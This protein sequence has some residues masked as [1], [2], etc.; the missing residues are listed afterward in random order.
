MLNRG[1]ERLH[2]ENSMSDFLFMPLFLLYVKKRV[3]FGN[4]LKL[5]FQGFIKIM[6]HGSL[7]MIMK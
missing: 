5:Y 4:F 3:T 7:D 2:G 1:Q 6:R